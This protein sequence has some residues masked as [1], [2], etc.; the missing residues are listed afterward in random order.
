MSDEQNARINKAFRIKGHGRE[1]LT[2]N[3]IDWLISELEKSKA[4]V[5]RLKA[6]L[7]I[8]HFVIRE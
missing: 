2:D 4:E 6:M 5:K 8:G 3:D 1:I 7:A